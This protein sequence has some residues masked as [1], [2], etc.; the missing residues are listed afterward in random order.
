MTELYPS[1]TSAELMRIHLQRGTP[2]QL[3][4]YFVLADNRGGED[5]YYQTDGNWRPDSEIVADPDSDGLR[6][7]AA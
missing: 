3:G 2:R 4:S 6:W 1:V 5:I 7:I